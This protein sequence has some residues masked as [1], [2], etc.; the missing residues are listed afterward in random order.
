MKLKNYS[1]V[2]TKY[3]IDKTIAYST[4]ITVIRIKYLQ[5]FSIYSL[6]VYNKKNCKLLQYFIC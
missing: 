5:I 3:I 4:I 1:I 6:N 2:P